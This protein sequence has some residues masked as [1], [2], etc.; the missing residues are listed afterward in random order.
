MLSSVAAANTQTLAVDEIAS[1]VNPFGFHIY[2]NIRG[3]HDNFS[4][5]PI[6]LFLVLKMLEEGS[7]GHTTTQLR[8]LLN[9]HD[10]AEVPYIRHL[11]TLPDSNALKIFSSAWHNQSFQLR[12]EYF[13][14]LQDKY[15]ADVFTFSED[16]LRE[17]N[18]KADEWISQRTSGKI[19]SLP[20]PMESQTMITLLNIAYFN[21][22][23]NL[24]FSTKNT[25]NR[26]FH[27]RQ[28]GP[29]KI[30]TMYKRSQL[31]YLDEDKYQV[32]GLPYKDN[33]YSMLLVVPKARK[34]LAGIEKNINE[35]EVARIF[36][37]M[38]YNDVKLY[39]PKFRIE[40]DFSIGQIPLLNEILDESA[41]FSGID[42]LNRPLGGDIIHKCYFEIDEKKTEAAAL[43]EVV[44]IG[45]GRGYVP[46]PPV[47]VKVN[48]PFLFFIMD[49]VHKT[50]VFMGRF[51]H[52]G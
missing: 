47:T 52:S 16:S 50:I 38:Q 5:S 21:A 48:R 7:S 8:Q 15:Q 40:S 32:V 3:D 25:K 6:S 2:Q 9:L 37:S 31:H 42:P 30:P 28:P 1:S 45:Y 27:S 20:V 17:I 39:L 24:E 41:D 36:S 19:N 18:Q 35:E 11:T 51:E 14:R 12:N 44:V 29:K 23:W 26:R 46:P 10:Q 13:G 49:N 43:S 22:E 34:G 33:A 4:F